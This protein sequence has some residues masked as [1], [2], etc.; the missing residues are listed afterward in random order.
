MQSLQ[1]ISRQPSMLGEGPC[2]DAEN[3]QLYWVDIEAGHIHR[4]DAA[5]GDV[6]TIDFGQKVGAV[7]LRQSGGLIVAAQHGIYLFD[8]ETKEQVQ[9]ANPEADMPNNRFNDGKCD[10]AG[11]FWAGT[12]SMI[13]EQGKGALYCV[14]PDF[15][16]RKAIE[17][18]S[19]SNGLVWSLD[20]TVFYY[21][22][23]PTF[24]ITAYDFRLIT[25]ELGPAS[26]AV[27]IPEELGTPDGMTIDAE[28]MLWVAHWGGSRVTRW[29]PQNGS[30]IGEISMP[31]TKPTCCTFG[32]EAF[33]QLFITSARLG[34]SEAELTEQPLNG[35]VFQIELDVKGMRANKFG[36]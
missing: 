24:Q 5:S 14:E 31:V 36:G 18:V 32:G 28:G 3:Q 26:V 23:S 12:M 30:L 35:A 16:V 22:D 6:Q 8:V 27:R 10:A 11:R 33:D 34:S 20:N 4:R 7:A 19:L 21:I 2:W 1:A 25:G 15:T 17:N 9:I 29:N 13:G